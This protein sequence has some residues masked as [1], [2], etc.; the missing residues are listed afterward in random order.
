M[1]KVLLFVFL[2]AAV[3]FANAQENSST[4]LVNNNQNTDY[5]D[6]SQWLQNRIGLYGSFFSGY[7]LSYQHQFENGF[8]LRTQLFAYGSN[9]DNSNYNSDEIRLAYGVDLQYNL[10]RTKNTRFYALLGSFID[11][12]ER[13]SSYYDTPNSVKD[14]DVE[15]Y[16]NI[17]IGFGIELMAWRNVSFMLE[18][19]YYGRFG[20]NDVTVYDYNNGQSTS[21]KANQTPT[22][23]GFGVGGGI[24]YAF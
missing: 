13:G 1:K 17:G 16:F 6:E 9:D 2:F 5:D 21:Y 10:K 14:Y 12:Y 11:Y 19:G 3:S 24:F 20:N 22:T 15:R 7:G 18:G 4:K 8:S 23:F